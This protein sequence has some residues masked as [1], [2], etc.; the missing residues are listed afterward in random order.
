MTREQMVAAQCELRRVIETATEAY[1]NLAGAIAYAD[2]EDRTRKGWRLED[3][4]DNR[5]ALAAS[6]IKLQ[7]GEGA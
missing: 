4:T 7:E 1:A 3:Y 5:T 6:V 2:I